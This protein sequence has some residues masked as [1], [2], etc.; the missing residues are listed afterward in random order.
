MSLLPSPTTTIQLA[1]S[2]DRAS[3]Y[4]VTKMKEEPMD[5]QTVEGDEVQQLGFNRY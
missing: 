5:V 2:H 1:D 3:F 4:V